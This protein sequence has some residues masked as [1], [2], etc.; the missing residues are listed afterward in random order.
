[1][2]MI[3]IMMRM[4]TTYLIQDGAWQWGVTTSGVMLVKFLGTGGAPSS[5]GLSRSS[6]PISPAVRWAVRLP[7]LEEPYE[8]LSS[9]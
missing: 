3:M 6:R 8:A 1:M 9:S 2:M 5:V 7:M 4:R